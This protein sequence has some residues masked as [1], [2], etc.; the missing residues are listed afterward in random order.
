MTKKQFNLQNF[1]NQ[2]SLTKTLRFELKPVGKTKEYYKEILPNDK[3]RD[4]YYHKVVKPILD[5]LHNNF[6]VDSLKKVQFPLSDLEESEKKFLNN[7]EIDNLLKK[8]RNVVTASFDKT[9]E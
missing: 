8:L 9:A 4:K 7:E 3:K 2:Y 6:I 1:T 5:D